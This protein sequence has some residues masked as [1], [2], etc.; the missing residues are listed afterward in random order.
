MS[1]AAMLM[2]AACICLIAA[3]ILTAG[4]C[5]CQHQPQ[6]TAHREPPPPQLTAAEQAHL[7]R[8]A[9]TCDRGSTIAGKE[10]ADHLRRWCPGVP[11]THIMRCVLALTSAAR[12]F[13][14][15]ELTATDAMAALI[16]ACEVA[17]VDLAQFQRDEIPR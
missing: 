8:L 2:T 9:R 6:P 10:L 1:P 5:A 11:D 16:A 14:R 12:T 17:A 7:A 4:R 13:A 15:E 3:V